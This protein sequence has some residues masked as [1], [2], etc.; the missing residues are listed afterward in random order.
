LGSIEMRA[1]RDRG[2]GNLRMG[3]LGNKQTRMRVKPSILGP[4]ESEH[5]ARSLIPY[6]NVG[7]SYSD[8]RSI[9]LAWEERSDFGVGFNAYYLETRGTMRK[10]AYRVKE[11]GIPIFLDNGAW[12]FWKKN[13]KQV[14]I[15][16][17]RK[18]IKEL[19]PTLVVA[20]DIIEDREGT[21]R[22][23]FEVLHDWE[24]PYLIPIQSMEE[25]DFIEDFVYDYALNR[26]LETFGIALPKWL[27]SRN[28]LIFLSL[29]RMEIPDA[30]VHILGF[31]FTLRKGGVRFLLGCISEGLNS[32]DLGTFRL[33]YS[34]KQLREEYGYFSHKH[35]IEFLKLIRYYESFT[36]SEI[37]ELIETLE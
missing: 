29:I 5:G 13:G 27:G 31:P 16:V 24:T 36:E 12:Q 18:W 28:I 22:Q 14:R 30:H 1:E 6:F 35:I 26:P 4:F 15:E 19:E 8:L 23:I 25:L 37:N 10:I 17:L 2:H 11:V 7:C 3:K 33:G 32:F 34:F 20:P 9:L 21:K